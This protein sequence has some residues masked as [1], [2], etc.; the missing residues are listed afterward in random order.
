[1]NLNQIVR[2]DLLTAELNSRL[3]SKV[4]IM[5]INFPPG[6]KAAYH[7]HPCPVVGYVASGKI[8]LQ[9]EGEP[10][11]VLSTGDGFYEPADVP[12]VHFDNYSDTE[13]AK[14][15]AFYLVDKEIELIELL[16]GK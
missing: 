13:P 7:K 6:Q 5:E 8:L 16:P 11:K 15:I 9:V 14:F 12:I 3:V 2:N 10:E 1:M 4:S